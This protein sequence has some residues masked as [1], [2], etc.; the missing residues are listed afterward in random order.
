MWA[1]KQNKFHKLYKRWKNSGYKTEIAPSFDR[2]DDNKGYALK[3]LQIV[4]WKENRAN[5]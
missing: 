3:R 1:L 5:Y 4:T 2:L